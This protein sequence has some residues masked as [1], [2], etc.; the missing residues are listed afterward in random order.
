MNRVSWLEWG[1]DWFDVHFALMAKVFRLRA[2][3]SRAFTSFS[4]FGFRGKDNGD[5]DGT[6]NGAVI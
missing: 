1:Q 6:E 3:D 2:Q 4:T 5:G